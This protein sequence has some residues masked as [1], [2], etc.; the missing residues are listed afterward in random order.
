MLTGN[1]VLVKTSKERVAP[2]FL[3]RDNPRWLEAA[4]SLLLIFRG[5]VGQSRG[6]ISE[7]V[8]TLIGEGGGFELLVHRGLA[9]LL[10][11]RAHF[12]VVSEV[13]PEAVRER[14]F[15]A[16]SEARCAMHASR[17]RVPFNREGVLEKVGKSFGLEPTQVDAALFADL[18]DE[19]RMISFDDV[20]AQAL[21]DRYNV[22]LVQAVLLR[23]VSVRLEIVRESPTATRQLF[24]KL[25]FHR[26]LFRVEPFREQGY[27][28]FIDGPLSLFSSTTRYGLQMACFFPSVLVCRNY[29]LE[30]EL[31]WGPKREPKSLY[32]DARADLAWPPS[33]QAY[34]PEEIGAF[35][36]RFRQVA[37]DWEVIESG[38]IIELGNEGVW[39]PDYRFVHRASGIDVFVEVL[40]FWKRSS[41]D[42]LLRLLPMHGPPRYLLAISDRLKV[43]ESSLEGLVGPV[44]RFKE[45]PSAPELRGM[46]DKFLPDKDLTRVAP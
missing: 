44:L 45:I 2:Q 41:V 18:K 9:K 33:G 40:G 21:I 20:S 19:N 32:L 23:A 17:Q 26:L 15:T 6:Q 35:I 13:S 1:L 22:A 4:E 3:E 7:E 8:E 5:A 29:R 24:R 14:V 30:A 42:R 28:I 27:R 25:K 16:A 37:P 36:E 46:L 12:E 38:E 11:D 34:V 31:R 43:D 10:E 39:V